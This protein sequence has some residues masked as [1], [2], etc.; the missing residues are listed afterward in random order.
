MLPDVAEQLRF[1]VA[2]ATIIV[3]TEEIL[4]EGRGSR[5]FRHVR[6]G[7]RT[8]TL[9]KS[10]S[11]NAFAVAVARGAPGCRAEIIFLSD[12]TASPLEVKPNALG[13]RVDDLAGFVSGILGG[14]YP[15]KRSP[16]TCPS[17]PSFFVCGPAPPGNLA[18]KN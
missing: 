12:E 1:D 10:K 4:V 9:M 3:E 13:K 5:V 6:T 8:D 18:K 7:H 2:G 17:C 11:L 15:P 14:R 16:R